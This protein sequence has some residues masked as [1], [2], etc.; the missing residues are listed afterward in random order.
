M[1]GSGA[2]V[3]YGYSLAYW[4]IALILVNAAVFA[5]LAVWGFFSIRKSP[6]KMK[7]EDEPSRGGQPQ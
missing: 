2:G 4:K 5:G 1:N 3:K 7:K 6:R